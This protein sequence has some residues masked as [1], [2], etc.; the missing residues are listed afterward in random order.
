MYVVCNIYSTAA[1][2]GPINPRPGWRRRAWGE[3]LQPLRAPGT[4]GSFGP[5]QVEGTRIGPRAQ[6]PPQRWVNTAA[7][8]ASIGLSP[9]PMT[10]ANAR[11]AAFS[12]GVALS[13]HKDCAASPR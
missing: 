4:T 8:A 5:A 2:R 7:C 12:A 10:F 6:V 3:C 9:A 13:A 11:P 1:C